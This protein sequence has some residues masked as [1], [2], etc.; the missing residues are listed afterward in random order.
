MARNVN[1]HQIPKSQLVSTW[2]HEIPSDLESEGEETLVT[3][4]VYEQA[5]P[6]RQKDEILQTQRQPKRQPK[7][8]PE[9]ESD[10]ELEP[11][12]PVRAAV[13]APVFTPKQPLY[14]T[15]RSPARSPTR[16]QPQPRQN[17]T[18]NHGHEQKNQTPQPPLS[19]AKPPTPATATPP[20][21]HPLRDKIILNFATNC[22]LC[23][24]PLLPSTPTP[25][26]PLSSSQPPTCP[27]C[28]QAHAYTT[29]PHHSP[30]FLTS[31]LLPISEVFSFDE[32]VAYLN[33]AVVARLAGVLARGGRGDRTRGVGRTWPTLDDFDFVRGLAEVRRGVF[34]EMGGGGGSGLGLD[35]FGMVRDRVGGR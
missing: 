10:P 9:P 23:H 31:H 18:P 32:T 30:S 14:P 2:L 4:S 5:Y 8:E 16:P 25:S 22:T 24:P 1:T 17:Q 15:L 28:I 6:R 26:P 3:P 20:T 33:Q 7:P 11:L 12:T 35:R 19:P 21:S 13:W 29:R 27:R 34:A